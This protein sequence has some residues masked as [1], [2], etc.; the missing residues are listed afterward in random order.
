M[1]KQQIS[2]HKLTLKFL[3]VQPFNKSSS[4]DSIESHSTVPAS[5]DWVIIRES[6]ILQHQVGAL[7]STVTHFRVT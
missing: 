5:I 7:Q 4:L 1:H 2:V 6:R 3:D